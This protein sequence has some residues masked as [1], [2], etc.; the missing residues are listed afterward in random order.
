MNKALSKLTFLIQLH[1]P[2]SYSRN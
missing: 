1:N 2:E